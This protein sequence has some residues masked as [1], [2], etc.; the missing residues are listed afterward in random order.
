MRIT[1]CILIVGA[2]L[3]SFIYDWNNVILGLKIYLG[4][5]TGISISVYGLSTLS[6]IFSSVEDNK[7]TGKAIREI[8]P[9]TH[10]IESL[11]S[12]ALVSILLWFDVNWLAN[13]TVICYA[14]YAISTISYVMPSKENSN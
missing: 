2:L 11:Y 10:I 3:S 4:I 7:K 14:L 12:L 8:S 6:Y 1:Y 5:T 9:S 13:M